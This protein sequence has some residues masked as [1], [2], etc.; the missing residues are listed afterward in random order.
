MTE[1]I[2]NV[3]QIQQIVVSEKPEM[4]CWVFYFFKYY[5]IIKKPYSET[6]N[7]GIN[8]VFCSI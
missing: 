8:K 5:K 6:F 1:T 4:T 3:Y 2:L 7:L